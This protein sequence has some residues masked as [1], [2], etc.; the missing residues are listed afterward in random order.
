M[1]KTLQDQLII[2][3]PE[4]W[5]G[6]ERLGALSGPITV[7][8][9]RTEAEATAA[10]ALGAVGRSVTEETFEA[11]GSVRDVNLN[12]LRR[13]FNQATSL[14][15]NTLKAATSGGTATESVEVT[16]A[17]TGTFVTLSESNS[18]TI[19]QVETPDLSGTVYTSATDYTAAT[20]TFKTITGSSIGGSGT[21]VRV[22][23]DYVPT[24]SKTL[25]V[26]GESAAF[27]FACRISGKL[28]DGDNVTLLVH[29]ATLVG[30]LSTVFG[31]TEYGELP[32]T[33]RGL[34]DVSKA[35]GNQLFQ[36]VLDQ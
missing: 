24:G 15:T 32:F 6:T 23:Y 12:G 4:V 26:G 17:A 20:N 10:H 8:Y 35:R 5:F 9:T 13:L 11:T 36:M 19:I 31:K 14:A 33:I 18:V 25:Q 7:T 27:E 2:G 28:Q 34:H 3:E 22:S 21:L 29:R 30:G 1:S 16:T